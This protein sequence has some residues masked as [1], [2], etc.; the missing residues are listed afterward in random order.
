MLEGDN[1][2]VLPHLSADW[3]GRVDAVVI[4]PPYDTGRRP[5][6]KH[7]LAYTDTRDD[8]PAFMA[9]RL[10]ACKPLLAPHAPV[11]VSIGPE[12]V[13]ELWFELRRAFPEHDVVTITVDTGGTSTSRGVQRRAEYLLIAVPPGVTL[14]GDGFT[15]GNVRSAFDAMTLSSFDKGSYP[16]QVYPVYVQRDTLRVVGAGPSVKQLID[17]GAWD[18]DPGEF[19]FDDEH[20]GQIPDGCAAIWPVTSRGQVKHVVWR[21]ARETFDEQ[22]AAGHVRAIANRS[23]KHTQP[24]TIQYLMAG[25]LRR[26]AAGEIAVLG[27]DANGVLE[28]GPA[29]PAG[30]AVPTIWAKPA[31]ATRNGTQRLDELLGT[32]HGFAYPK[33][34]ELIADIVRATCGSR[35]DAVV[36]DFFAGSATLMDA[37]AQLN[38]DGGTRRA[39][40]VT[41][42]EHGIVDRV[43]IPRMAAVAARHPAETFA[44]VREGELVLPTAA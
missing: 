6:W 2:D 29:K 25:V 16:N 12:R 41:S 35:H 8:W 7:G 4:D 13:H 19:P 42:P 40:M 23:T 5:S 3:A 32:G 22:L 11:A 38:A 31:Y 26:I 36:L 24:A 17:Q 43:T 20:A 28:V 37:L 34:V 14:G 33:P 21:M 9:E 27:R 1:L 15:E 44:V 39:L 10:E 18:G 30:A